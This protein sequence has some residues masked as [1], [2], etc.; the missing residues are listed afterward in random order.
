VLSRYDARPP[1]AWTFEDLPGGKPVLAPGTAPGLSFNLSHTHGLVACAV[2]RDTNVGIDVERLERSTC[3]DDLAQRYF[4]PEE[5][6]GLAACTPERRESY[7]LDL[8]TLKEAYLKAI[9]VGLSH[10]LNAMAF[11]L[12]DPAQIIFRPPPRVEQRQWQFALFEPTPRHRMAVA[13]QRGVGETWRVLAE[14]TAACA[15]ALAPLR[16]SVP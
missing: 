9:G 6:A 13:V 5:T 16:T 1:A 14:C 12:A 7:F 10:P 15:T 2:T 8:W 3:I 4:T 11:D